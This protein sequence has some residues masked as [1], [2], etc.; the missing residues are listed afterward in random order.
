MPNTYNAKTLT[1]I[2]QSGNTYIIDPMQGNEVAFNDIS[3]TIHTSDWT[4][5]GPYIYTYSDTHFVANSTV[6]VRFKDGI[7]TG[8]IGDLKYSKT[9][10]QIQFTTTEE[11]IG[12][13]PLVIQVIDANVSGVYPI[14]ATMIET[15]AI[16]GE[17]TVEGALEDL[18][19]RLT[20]LT[21]DVSNLLIASYDSTDMAIVFSS[22]E[23]A[24]YDSTDMSISINV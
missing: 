10:G 18:D 20:N 11:P 8:L 16:V 7:R 21:E 13:I 19:T 14:D 1:M 17:T 6:D 3:I 9:T 15:E 23:V 24:S 2:D 12:D 5:S 4:G 22:S